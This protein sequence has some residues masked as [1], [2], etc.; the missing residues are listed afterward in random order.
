MKLI[1]EIARLIMKI[2]FH[3]NIKFLFTYENFDKNRT[4]PYVLIANH[5]SANDPLY[6]S[7]NI[8]KYPYPVANQFL[9]THP[10]L[11]FALSKMIY[12]IPKRKGQ[13]DTTAIRGMMDAIKNKKNPIL[14]MPEG[15]ASVFGE[16]SEGY[17]E[18]TAKLIKKLKT[19][20]VVAKIHG[21]YLTQPR[22]GKLSKRGFLHIHYYRLYEEEDIEKL[23]SDDIL[24]DI[25]QHL[26]FNDFEWNRNEKH[27]YNN[28]KR[29][30]GLEQYIHYCPKC[31]GLQTLSTKGANVF[32]QKCG[33]I[34]TFN[35]QGFIEGL[36]FDDLVTWGK[37][38]QKQIPEIAKEQ[39][40]TTGKLLEID[41]TKNK[42]KLIGQFDFTL[43]EQACTLVNHKK[44]IH[45]DIPKM[46]GLVLN[47]TNYLSFDYEDKTFVF[48]IKDPI[49]FYEVITYKKGE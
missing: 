49:L 5:P 17:F 37:L 41:F 44:N 14:L 23:S 36:P 43:K 10:L 22:W 30:L 29:A 2:L 15:N 32:C 47:Q 7:M 40:Q 45:F 38:Q 16:Q 11:G 12:S 28:K 42:R 34:A 4:T 46:S 20:V 35:Q 33:Q 3:K 8:K 39:I 26:A 18:S 21:G 1:Q 13:N 24:K 19:E 31:E 48:K 9:Y 27:Q 6:I 25:H